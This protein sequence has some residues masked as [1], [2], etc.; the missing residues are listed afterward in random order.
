MLSIGDTPINF[1]LA[2][3]RGYCKLFVFKTFC[4]EMLLPVVA[5]CVVVSVVGSGFVVVF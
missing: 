5:C 2:I 3:I 4:C 1:L